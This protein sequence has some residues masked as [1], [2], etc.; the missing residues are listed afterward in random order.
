M[1]HNALGRTRRQVNPLGLRYVSNNFG[2][3]VSLAQMGEA[4]VTSASIR[5]YLHFCRIEKGLSVNSLDAYARDLNRFASYLSAE[6]LQL[7][8]VS[9][10]N[11][12]IYVDHLRSCGLSARSLARHTTAIRSFFNFLVEE[13]MVA[14][15]PAELLV[16]P[17]AASALPKFLDVQTVN[18]IS[19]VEPPSA[20]TSAR[21]RA[22]FELLYACG[23]RVTELTRLRVVDLDVDSGVIRVVGKNN[24]QR[25]VPVGRAALDFVQTYISRERAALLKGRG[26]PYLF[27]T[28]RGSALTRQGFWKL[29]RQRALAAGAGRGVHPHV[30]RHTFATHLLEGGAD[31]RSVQTML[32]HA[33]IGTTQ[34]YTHVISSTLQKVVNKHHPRARRRAAKNIPNNGRNT[35]S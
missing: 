17:K 9:L 5:A 28:A 16:A 10:D 6:G 30:L 23:L 14:S 35:E 25:L 34:I 8:S 24:K 27:V 1:K 31:L 3:I 15:N 32:G 2:V 33:D 26:S 18:A 13:G 19:E 22:M 20:R 12:R 29:L 11:L 4:P 7:R 21:D